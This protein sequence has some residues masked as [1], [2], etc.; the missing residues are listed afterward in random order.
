MVISK[1][2]GSGVGGEELERI[3]RHFGENSSCG[4]DLHGQVG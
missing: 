4:T 1:D 2:Q 3:I